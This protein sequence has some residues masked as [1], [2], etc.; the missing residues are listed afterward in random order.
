MP[1]ATPII[2]VE[3]SAARRYV[4]DGYYFW[5]RPSAEYT[6]EEHDPLFAVINKLGLTNPSNFDDKNL[7]S[8][9]DQ[10]EDTGAVLDAMELLLDFDDGN[11]L[12]R[13]CRRIRMKMKRDTK[14][15]ILARMTRGQAATVLQFF[16][17]MN[18]SLM[19]LSNNISSST[20]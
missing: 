12:K 20:D 3:P 10:L 18:F 15:K 11:V 8:Y 19:R 4:I 2:G 7:I 14:R 9:F 16:F 17:L 1:Q 13:L 5:Q 6:L